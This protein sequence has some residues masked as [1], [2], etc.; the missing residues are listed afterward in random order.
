VGGESDTCESGDAWSSASASA[1]TRAGRWT[2]DAIGTVGYTHGQYRGFDRSGYLRGELRV[3]PVRLLT[4]IAGGQTS[5]ASWTA[6]E[7]GAVFVAP[8]RFDVSL[9]YRPEL[10]DYVAST[11]PELVHTVTADARVAI[12][13]A[14]DVAL[15]ALGSKGADRDALA[16][17]ATL[18]WR[19]LP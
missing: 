11:G 4:G 13:T 9:I 3:D 5:F 1:G 15:S 10:L 8:R 2:V 12:S 18:V 17:L 16:L 7:I 6:G 14:L 19:P